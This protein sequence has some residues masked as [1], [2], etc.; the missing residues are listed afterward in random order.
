MRA[1]APS[2]GVLMTF[3]K[4]LRMTLLLLAACGMAASQ[5]IAD[6]A[7]E[8]RQAKRTPSANNRVFTNENLR[9]AAVEPAGADKAAVSD[10]KKEGAPGDDAANEAKASQDKAAAIAAM[11][12]Q[13][14][15]TATEITQ[16]KRELDIMQRENRLRAAAYYGD[17]GTKLR[18]SAAAAEFDRKYQADLAAKQAAIAAAETQLE[19]LK[20]EARRAGVP[21]GQLY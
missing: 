6:K 2:L 20:T 1:K 11:K 21:A 14:E 4:L 9:S 3:Q 16:L 10:D 12:T 15:K 18:D 17:A 5:T 19:R 8:Y 7:R 13:I